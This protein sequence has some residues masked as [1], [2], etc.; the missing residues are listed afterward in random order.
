M[1][2]VP[3]RR[4][5]A[6]EPPSGRRRDQ[7][8]RR[9]FARRELM[10]GLYRYGG[11]RTRVCLD[12]IG[13]RPTR[14]ARPRRCGP[15]PLKGRCSARDGGAAFAVSSVTRPGPTPGCCM[16]DDEDGVGS[17]A[18]P[19]ARLWEAE[20]CPR[21]GADLRCAPDLDPPTFFGPRCPMSTACFRAAACIVPFARVLAGFLV[22]GLCAAARAQPPP[23]WR[24]A[25]G[26]AQWPPI[27]RSAVLHP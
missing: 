6:G 4:P 7:G 9:V 24:R 13:L 18:A 11:S 3:G 25:R 26:A 17:V 8:S 5:T 1:S 19:L 14:R 27:R 12:G 2:R 15:W 21:D 23:S 20:P 10:C 16:Q 22:M